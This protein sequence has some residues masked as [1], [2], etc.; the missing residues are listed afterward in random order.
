MKRVTSTATDPAIW[1]LL[2]A[3]TCG[4]SSVEP[5]AIALLCPLLALFTIIYG[6]RIIVHQIRKTRIRSSIDFAGVVFVTSFFN[7]IAAYV[8]GDLLQHLVTKSL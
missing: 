4:Y 6:S 8:V 3:T 2:G 5:W 1:G 7:T